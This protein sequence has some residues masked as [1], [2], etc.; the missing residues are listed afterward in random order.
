MSTRKP[1][2][3]VGLQLASRLQAAAA[4]D[5]DGT[6]LARVTA[7]NRARTPGSLAAAVADLAE[8]AVRRAGLRFADASAVVVAT[9]GVPD[10]ATRS[11]QRAT[12]PGVDRPGFLDEL[13]QALGTGC[14]VENDVNLAAV[15]EHRMGA[16]VGVSDFVL[17]SLRPGLGLSAFVGGQLHRGV[18]G[19]AGEVA[20]VPLVAAHPLHTL[21][22]LAA[23][24]PASS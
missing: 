19:A 14:T 3:V 12:L 17:V 8:N 2:F 21:T 9:P 6:V 10:P 5:L 23:G 24:S 16:A 15:A 4:A 7:P 1:G 20:I 18:H 11:V 22:R 13:D